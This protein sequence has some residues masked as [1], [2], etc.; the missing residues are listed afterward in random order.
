M[1]VMS[2]LAIAI[3]HKMYF[4]LKSGLMSQNCQVM[5]FVSELCLGLND[6]HNKSLTNC[7]S[8]I[9]IK[10]NRTD[11]LEE[12]LNVPLT[13]FLFVFLLQKLVKESAHHLV[14]AALSAPSTQRA[15]SNPPPYLLH[16]LGSSLH[17]LLHLL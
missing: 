15:V 4:Y 16:R 3:K 8:I 10:N 2:K 5:H 1:T 6:V 7:D 12:T 17:L 9:V 11:V 13:F 14:V